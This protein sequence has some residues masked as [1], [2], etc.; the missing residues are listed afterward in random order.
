MLNDKIGNCTCAAAGHGIQL[1]T[2]LATRKEVTVSDSSILKAYEDVGGYIINQPSTDNGANMLDVQNYWRSTGIEGHKI[3][4]Y[5]SLDLNNINYIKLGIQL[6]GYLN[7]GVAMPISAQRQG[8]WRVVNGSDGE[9]WGWGGHDVILTDYD[10]FGLGCVT[11]GY[12]Q[13]MTWDFFLKYCE[14][15]YAILSKDWL[16]TNSTISGSGFD[17]STLQADLLAIKAAKLLAK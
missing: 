3:D 12:R 4:A 1:W 6:F 16:R 2:F 10:R 7:I 11:W 15:R 9:P 14:E 17:W 5:V 8:T 13:R